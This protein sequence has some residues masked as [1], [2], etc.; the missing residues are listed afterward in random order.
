MNPVIPPYEWPIS[1]TS[2][3]DHGCFAMYSSM[4]YLPSSAALVLN[5]SNSPP[6]QPVPRT[7]ACTV[8]YS[9]LNRSLNWRLSSEGNTGRS[10]MPK[11]LSSVPPSA[12]PPS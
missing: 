5:R 2:P 9:S 12:E 3:F 8:T 6:E 1:A 7:D 4:T 10:V 11:S